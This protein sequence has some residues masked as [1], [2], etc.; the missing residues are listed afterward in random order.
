[1]EFLGYDRIRV[2]CPWG[3]QTLKDLEIN[4]E[5]NQHATVRFTGIVDEKTGL[6][7]I[8]KN[9]EHDQIQVVEIDENDKEKVIFTAEVLDVDIK[10]ENGIYHIEAKGISGTFYLDIEK[11][12]RSFQNTAMT[13]RDVIKQVIKDTSKSD[14]IFEA[15]EKESISVPRIQYRESDWIFIKRMA[16]HSGAVVVPEVTEIRSRFWFGMPQGEKRKISSD[17]EYKVWKDIDR[18]REMA[19]ERKGYRPEDFFYYEIKTGEAYNIGDKVT[20][21]NKEMII[22]SKKAK[23]EKGL[24]TYTYILGFQPG[25][26]LKK[27]YNH[28]ISGMSIKGKVLDTQGENLKVHLDI[29][30]AQDKNTA[31]WYKYIP[32]TGNTMYCMPKIGTE[33]ALYFSNEKE[34]S[35]EVIG[36][37]RTNGSQCKGTSNPNNRYL[38]TE[39]NKQMALLPG[40]ISF[41][42]VGTEDHPLKITLQDK[43][44][45]EIQEP[46]EKGIKFESHQSFLLKAKGKIELFA[47]KKIMINA[48]TY[49]GMLKGKRGSAKVFTLS[50]EFNILGENTYL[51]GRKSELFP[52]YDDAPV[53]KPFNWKKLIVNVLVAAVVV[54]AV[55]FSMGVVGGLMLGTVAL[56]IK[57]TFAVKAVVGLATLA[58]G[59][60]CVWG[61]YE[62]YKTAAEDIKNG[63]VREGY[64]YVI[65]AA[66]TTFWKGTELLLFPAFKGKKIVVWGKNVGKTVLMDNTRRFLGYVSTGRSREED[67]VKDFISEAAEDVPKAA[68]TNLGPGAAGWQGEAVNV[69]KDRAFDKVKDRSNRKENE[70]P[71]IENNTFTDHP[72]IVAHNAMREE[73]AKA[74]E[75]RDSWSPEKWGRWKAEEDRIDPD[76]K[77]RRNQEQA[78]RIAPKAPY[79]DVDWQE[80]YG[81]EA[82]YEEKMKELKEQE[83]KQQQRHD[84]PVPSF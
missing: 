18:Y 68:A 41:T 19:G 26:G 3:L 31:Y 76:G 30:K 54:V 48:P 63:E 61:G 17:V 73:K 23:M 33:V 6:S 8:E 69:V 2:K 65:P 14:A 46:I 77:S 45:E 81:I 11:K 43:I 32:P 75:E 58:F 38:T 66:K 39:H 10:E 44:E 20:F 79:T 21:K 7:T 29:D 53:K 83:K 9:V 47:E 64:D 56:A 27:Q 55:A 12:S 5:P 16:S 28:I 34:E 40:L 1:M 25:F 15:G 42:G 67:W 35:A 60:S 59:G 62:I 57:G 50:D 72:G 36:C 70:L 82:G 51:Y 24:W 22:T 80:L 78:E 74:R 52:Q 13:Y 49:V 84:S 4:I 71:K 37:V